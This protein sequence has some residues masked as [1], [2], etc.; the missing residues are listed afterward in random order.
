MKVTGEA[1]VMPRSERFFATP[2]ALA[3]RVLLYITRCGHY[4][5]DGSYDFRDSSE[6]GQ[7]ESHRNFL[8][9]YVRAGAMR[10]AADGDTFTA[11]AGQLA[12]LDCRRPHRFRAAPYVETLWLHFDGLCAAAFFEQIVTL[13]GGRHLLE[14]AGVHKLES[15]L[16]ALVAGVKSG[17]EETVRSSRLYTVLCALLLPGGGQDAAKGPVSQ[18]MEYIGAHLFE[19]L[20]VDQ[21]AAAVNVSPSHFSRQFRG[22]TGFSPHE[23]IVLH[24]I[25]EAKTLLLETDLTVREIADRVGYHSEVNFIA[26]F[27]NKVGVS[28]ASFRRHP[29]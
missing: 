22:Q 27:Q 12:L 16:T 28:P 24:R 2:S 10:Y 4:Y 29:V 3:R 26:S 21:L 8:L 6:V 7:L 14:P 18:A 25:D 5:C 9:S 1:G 13:R 19:D 20:P 15:L 23:Y 11:T 17:E